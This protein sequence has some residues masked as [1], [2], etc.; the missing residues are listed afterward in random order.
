M[1]LHVN[2]IV[3]NASNSVVG[4]SII[5]GVSLYR[6]DPNIKN[7]VYCYAIHN[8]DWEEWNFALRVSSETTCL[9]SGVYRSLLL[10]R[11]LVL[12]DM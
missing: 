4:V 1:L 10:V 11:S 7:V 3:Q 5:V 9:F 2:I 12:A 6:I 8:G